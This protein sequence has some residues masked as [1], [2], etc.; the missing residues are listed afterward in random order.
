MIEK[1]IM[2][3]LMGDEGGGG[4]LFFSTDPKC[5]WSW[6]GVFVFR[7]K[8]LREVNLTRFGAKG[9]KCNVYLRVTTRIF[10]FS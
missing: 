10:C 4:G 3:K 9:E 1:T 8:G 7:K 6:W 2:Q 5:L